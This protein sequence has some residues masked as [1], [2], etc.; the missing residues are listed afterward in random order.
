MYTFT[1]PPVYLDSGFKMVYNSTTP[2]TVGVLLVASNI[3][4]ADIS[5]VDILTM[6][7]TAYT[8]LLPAT[9][10]AALAPL[11]SPIEVLYITEDGASPLAITGG[12]KIIITV[13]P[14]Q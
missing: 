12:A 11:V 3:Q 4:F 6:C 1:P 10:A 5:S 13:R 7:S 8:A 14:Q 9:A 2:L